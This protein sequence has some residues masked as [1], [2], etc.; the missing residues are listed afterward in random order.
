[1]KKL[2]IAAAIVCAAAMTQ[3]AS[4]NWMSGGN[5]VDATDKATILEAVPD[6]GK[7]VL[8][9][10]GTSEETADWSKATFVQEGEFNYSSKRGGS[11]SVA[12]Q[13]NLTVGT[14]KNGYVY[15]VMLQD[16]AGNLSQLQYT[17]G[18]V[19]DTKYVLTGFTDDT[20]TLGDFTFTTANYTVGA[21]PEPTS[22]L[23][24]LLG[25][26]GLALRRRRA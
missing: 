26:A 4:F 11:N 12:G 6:G 25:V 8:C 1:M 7:I 15:G 9:L 14:Q 17:D 2:M 10:L 19:L 20:S 13:Y 18:T 23:L 3:A 24:L 16:S 21:V 5:L 22:G